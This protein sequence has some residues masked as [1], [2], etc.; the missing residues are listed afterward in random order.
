MNA[1]QSEIETYLCEMMKLAG[2]GPERKAQCPRASNHNHGDSD[3]SCRVNVVRGLIYCHCG[4]EGNIEGLWRE[5]GWPCPP[6]L[7][8]HRD[9]A[10]QKPKPY[11]RIWD[12]TLFIRPGKPAWRYICETRGIAIENFPDDVRCH[13]A[14]AYY[15]E[16]KKTG[17]FPAIVARVRGPKRDVRGI[18]RIYLT[19]AGDKARVLNCKMSLG[20]IGGGAIYLGEP[21]PVLNVAEGLETSLAIWSATKSFTC[22]AVSTSGMKRF[23]IPAEVKTLKIWADRDRSEIGKESARELAVRAYRHGFTVFVL[24]PPGS[25]AEGKNSRDWL[26]VY[27]QDGPE[28]LLIEAQR[29]EP[30]QPQAVINSGLTNGATAQLRLVKDLCPAVAKHIPEDLVFPTGYSL[31]DNQIWIDGDDPKLLSKTAVFIVA[32]K[33]RVDDNIRFIKAVTLAEDGSVSTLEDDST[34][35]FDQKKILTLRQRWGIDAN[36]IQARALVQYFVTSERQNQVPLSRVAGSVGLM[37]HS[38]LSSYLMG[39][40]AP[41]GD[42]LLSFQPKSKADEEL[43]QD[44]EP[45]GTLERWKEEYQKIQRFPA[46]LFACYFSLIPPLKARNILAFDNCT[47]H[48]CSPTS[49]GKSVAQQICISMMGNPES[50]RLL[51]Q[52]EATFTGTEE[53]IAQFKGL[54]VFLEDSQQCKSPEQRQAIIYAV[55]N[56]AFRRRSKNYKTETIA[57]YEGVLISS[58]EYSLKEE[59]STTGMDARFIEL[60]GSPFERFDASTGALVD[61]IQ[62]GIRSNY[63]HVWPRWL[64][65]VMNLDLG[66]REEL[67]DKFESIK[68]QLKA[69]AQGNNILARRAPSFAASAIAGQWLHQTMGFSDPNHPLSVVMRIFERVRED[70][71]NCDQG[72]EALRR[73]LSWARANE[74]F[75]LKRVDDN[76]LS[77]G[78]K[79]R[80]EIFGVMDPSFIAIYPHKLDRI[81][82]EFGYHPRSIKTQWRDDRVIQVSGSTKGKDDRFSYLVRIG[83]KQDRLVKIVD[84]D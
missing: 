82:K 42:L 56:G 66:R 17:M 68:N 57:T 63:G 15:E 22:A 80:G 53:Q 50:P 58:G 37:E 27:N 54:P 79:P 59:S 7:N 78:D 45:R 11:Q 3:P 35:F 5:L 10:D 83:G 23:E 81:L 72:T 60:E 41:I 14:L 52:W 12:D 76:R 75:F 77:P 69:L 73:I 28:A 70:E 29:G 33:L 31:R 65:Y 74:N 46:V 62:S 1:T 2:K 4:L 49:Q 18:H 44:F 48:F 36:C 64:E 32:N 51:D 61:E 40:C 16:K 38:G 25:I 67:Q 30:W 13:L 24:V 84:L 43:G 71:A 8:G 55:G 26:D 20:K 39:N 6:W 19:R 21:G 9:T 47:L 34:I